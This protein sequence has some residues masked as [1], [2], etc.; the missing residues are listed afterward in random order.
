MLGTNTSVGICA[1]SGAWSRHHR[2]A[3]EVDRLYAK[4]E[5]AEQ[6][7]ERLWLMAYDA[8]DFE[9][10]NSAAAAARRAEEIAHWAFV[11]ASELEG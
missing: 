3:G 5:R 11:E 1:A 2:D 7:A 8:Q 10:S 6:V 9:R 4:A